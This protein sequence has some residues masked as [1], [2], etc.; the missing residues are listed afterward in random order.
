MNPID[1]DRG[2]VPQLLSLPQTALRLGVCKRTV[3]RLI[4]DQQIH[5]CKVG[6]STRITVT[7]LVR[8]VASLNGGTTETSGMP[9]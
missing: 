9:T 8:F 5:A 2:G 4:G 7:E 6:R 3:E 1:L